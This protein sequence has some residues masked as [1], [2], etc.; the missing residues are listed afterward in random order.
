MSIQKELFDIRN[1]MSRAASARSVELIAV[2]K[3]LSPHIIRSAYALGLRDFG[4]NKVQEFL[5]KYDVL[6][7]DIRW[8]MIGRLQTNKVKDV[9]GKIALIHSLDRLELYD[10]L[11][12][13]ARK[14]K[15]GNVECLLQVNISGEASKAGLAACEI[16]GFL[17]QL[18]PDSPVQIK[19]LMTI[20]PLTENKNEIRNV[21]RVA[22]TLF[23]KLKKEYA[24]FDWKYLSMGMSGDFEIAIEEGAT[25]VRIGTAL[26]GERQKQ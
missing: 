13:E 26:F 9:L 22:K 4:E 14:R 3:T 6:P 21:F 11:D 23:E 15:T 10:K 20:A 1:R 12:A 2:T 16:D 8:H 18:K 7:G 19:G 25:M 5:E 17:T 24:Q